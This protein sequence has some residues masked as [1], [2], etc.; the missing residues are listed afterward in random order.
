MLPDDRSLRQSLGT[1]GADIVFIEHI[2]RI[3]TAAKGR[4]DFVLC[5]DDFGSQ[6]APLISPATFERFS[7]PYLKKVFG[8]WRAYG[9]DRKLLHICGDS[10]DV[11]TLYA[12]T[13]ADMVEIDNV[14]GLRGAK[15]R[16]G[17][18]VAIVGN[19]HTVTELLQGTPESVA[20]SAQRCIDEAGA[21]G[22]LLLGSGCLVP[23]NAP[24]EN[25]KAMVAVA[26]S[27]PYPPTT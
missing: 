15:D 19:V 1:R 7:Y 2:E 27:Q 6:R 5:G 13:G 23:R 14:V 8:A 10:T 18:R 21:G 20:T 24:V 3:L 12:D 9:I 4:I 25:V 16:I 17:D 11:L 22:G 26:H